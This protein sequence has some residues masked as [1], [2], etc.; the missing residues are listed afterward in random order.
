[1]WAML[2]FWPDIK[3]SIL[4]CIFLCSR[5]HLKKIKQ[6]GH[7]IIIYIYWNDIATTQ[8]EAYLLCYDNR[9]GTMKIV[10]NRNYL[11]VHSL[12]LKFEIL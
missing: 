9:K 11:N 3:A 8:C 2:N 5:M 12:H 10:K 1:M 4:L 7:W 6:T